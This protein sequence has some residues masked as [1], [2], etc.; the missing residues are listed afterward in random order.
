MRISLFVFSFF[1]ACFNGDIPVLDKTINPVTP[2]H[3]LFE[4][5]D[6]R[7]LVCSAILSELINK[8]PQYKLIDSKIARSADGQQK[9]VFEP[10]KQSIL[11][12]YLFIEK[13][14]EPLV[15]GKSI[16]LGN[17]KLT[18][19]EILKFAT[20]LVEGSENILLEGVK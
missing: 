19:S 4:C 15:V 2:I 7:E 16:S 17:S 3:L 10:S 20:M 18:E 14:N 9:I 11:S 8:F 6:N 12:G 13:Q 5:R 1:S